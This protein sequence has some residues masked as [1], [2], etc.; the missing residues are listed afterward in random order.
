VRT[1]RA[2]L[3]TAQLADGVKPELCRMYI[4][5]EDFLKAEILK[6][7]NLAA[8]LEK[9][10]EKQVELIKDLRLETKSIELLRESRMAAYRK[11]EIKENER[12]V[13]EFVNTSRLMRAALS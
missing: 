7:K 8:R 5:Y 9:R 2:E 1:N 3:Q 13:E 10:I 4:R 12:L 11:E 6:A